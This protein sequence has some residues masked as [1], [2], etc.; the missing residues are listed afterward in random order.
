MPDPDSQVSH[1]RTSDEKS[2]VSETIRSPGAPLD[3]ATRAFFDRRFGHSFSSVR[4]HTD[5]R[6]AHSA[7]ALNALAYTVGSEIVFAPGKYAPWTEKGKAL[8]AHEL[9]HVVQQGSGAAPPQQKPEMSGPLDSA[10]R[11]ADAVAE[12]AVAPE[13][14]PYKSPALQIRQRLRNS[15]VT[16][17]TIQRAPVAT[18]AGKFVDDKYKTVKDAA[19]KKEIGVS[20][21]LRFAP[22]KHVDAKKIGMAQIVNSQDK[23]KVLAVGATKKARKVIKA[24]SIAKGKPG[25]GFHIDQAPYNRNPLYAVEKPPKAHTTLAATPPNPGWGQHGFRFVN[26]AGKLK[27]QDA[28]ITDTPTLPGHG[29]N[30]SQIFETTALAIA[31]TQEGTY[32]GSVQWGWQTDAAGK[33]SK[34]PLTLKSNDVP[35]TIFAAAAELWGKTK[36]SKGEKP[37]PLPVALGRYTSTERVWLVSNPSKYKTTILGK[38]DK[39]TR[40]EV[41]SK[42]VGERFNRTIDKF[43]WWKVTIVE[44]THIGK[45]GW[46]MQTLLSEKKTP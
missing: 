18:W 38:L 8:L 36:T 9:S 37:I 15:A 25:A 28:W 14:A 35:S 4:V 13:D 12:E 45:V 46:V 21:K 40:L 26:K 17:P 34:L 39:N 29:K 24:R 30:A 11:V 44:G 5:Q 31:G 3:A 19:G 23:G 2:G 22:G 27:R 10:E 1:D 32:Y 16:G 33:F 20:T 42:G 43:K 7:S 41:T 6:A